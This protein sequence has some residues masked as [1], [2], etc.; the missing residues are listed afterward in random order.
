VFVAEVLHSLDGP[1]GA[2]FEDVIRTLFDHRPPDML[3]EERGVDV[4]RS[5]LV[6]DVGDLSDERRVL[7]ESGDENV[8]TF[9]DVGADFDGELREGA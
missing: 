5:D 2:P 1:G 3:I 8:L 7:D 4:A 6:R 9:A